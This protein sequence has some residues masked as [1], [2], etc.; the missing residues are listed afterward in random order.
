[1]SCAASPVVVLDSG[2]GGLTVVRS[3]RRVLPNEDIVYFGDTARLPYGTK[4]A[5]TVTR[6]VREIINYLRP[7]DPKHVVIACNTASALSLATVRESFPDLII[8]GV[9]DAGAQ[10]AARA[11]RKTRPTVAVIATEATTRSRA[12]AIAIKH[13]LPEAELLFR[14]TPLL[15][16]LIEEG[17][18]GDDPV[19][20]LA[21]KQY[22]DPLL[23]RRPDVLVLGCTHYP[24]LKSTIQRLVGL[25]IAV[26]DAADCCAEDVHQRL[27]AR[28][29]VRPVRD[30]GASLQCFVTDDSP[31]FAALGSRF[32]GME[33][34]P[35]AL[36]APDDLYAGAQVG[37]GL[38]AMRRAV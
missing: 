34:A 7:F 22:L 4:T 19:V 18:T 32:L 29:L 5:A 37:D 31:R 17:R 10:A 8:T 2:L 35:P 21:L 13:L 11:T 3:L 24:V 27:S 16:P 30:G 12:Y 26:I 36:V 1:M 9:V 14:A 25:N 23:R 6:F 20:L 15:V 33:I 28:G 38:L